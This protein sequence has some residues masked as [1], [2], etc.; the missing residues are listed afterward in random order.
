[1]PQIADLLTPTRVEADCGARSRK[2]VLERLAAL[3]AEGIEQPGEE[4]IARALQGREEL[5]STGLGHGIAIPHGRIGGIAQP[6]AAFVRLGEGID[7]E[8]I[9]MEPVDLFFALLVPEESTDEHLDILSQLATRFSDAG[10]LE[11]LRKAED[12]WELYRLL[13]DPQGQLLR[14][15]GQ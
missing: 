15:Q 4:E 2:A 7:F 14:A 1:M 13:I 11:R 9:D 8:A 6:R 5:G 10:Y 3:L 12:G